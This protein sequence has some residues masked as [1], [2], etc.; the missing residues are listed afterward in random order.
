[1]TNMTK[2]VKV[3]VLLLAATASG[4]GEYVDQGRSPARVIINTLEASRG[5]APDDFGNPLSSDVLTNVTSPDPCTTSSPC[6]TVFNDL[7]QVTMSLVLRDP[8]VPGLAASP[9]S[10]NQVTFTRYRVEY[11]RTDGRATQGVD[12]PYAFDS[13]ITFTVPSSGNITAS[14]ELV[15]SVAKGEAPLRALVT[16]RDQIATIAY[17]TFY[18]RDLAGND[19]AVTGTIAVNFGNFG[20]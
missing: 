5:S 11:K 9:S 10:L 4:C 17:V 6:P 20:D 16:N 18:G 3:A 13:G 8:G 1:M 2:L 14:F 7:G 15:R 19:V 12:V